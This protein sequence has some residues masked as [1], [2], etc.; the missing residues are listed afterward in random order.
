MGRKQTTFNKLEYL[1]E[2]LTAPSRIPHYFNRGADE[3]N[4]PLSNVYWVVVACVSPLKNIYVNCSVSALNVELLLACSW[5]LIL[6]RR[7]VHYSFAVGGEGR[8]PSPLPSRLQGRLAGKTVPQSCQDLPLLPVLCT[9]EEDSIRGSGLRRGPFWIR[10]VNFSF[11]TEIIQRLRPGA[12]PRLA[13]DGVSQQWITCPSLN[14]I[15]D[16]VQTPVWSVAIEYLAQFPLLNEREK[17][18][19]AHTHPRCLCAGG[20]LVERGWPSLYPAG[21]ISSKILILDSWHLECFA[22]LFPFSFFLICLNL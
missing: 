9:C 16:L 1:L 5:Y 8:C 14:V 15:A 12:P 11:F 2:S 10:H 19:R 13:A 7:E 3:N 17:E 22:L 20:V 6:R 18:L 4:C 21:G